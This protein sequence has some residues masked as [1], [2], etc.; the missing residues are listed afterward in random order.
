MCKCGLIRD[1]P[2][3]HTA[4]RY[5]MKVVLPKSGSTTLSKVMEGTA[6]SNLMDDHRCPECKQS[7]TTKEYVS[8]KKLPK[9]LIVQAPRVRHKEGDDGNYV[10]DG[11]GLP[12]IHK[13]HTSVEFP[14]ET[15]DLSSLVCGINSSEKHI[16]EAFCTIMHSGNG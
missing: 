15:L 13:I 2:S 9:Y 14:A 7:N 6:T 8:V 11:Q 10:L 16:Y 1:P 4:D 5:A 12:I 3:Q